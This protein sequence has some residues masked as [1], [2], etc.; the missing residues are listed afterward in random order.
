MSEQLLPKKEVRKWILAM[1]FSEGKY[2]FNRNPGIESFSLAIH[3]IEMLSPRNPNDQM[4]RAALY[5]TRTGGVLRLLEHLKFGF[6]NRQFQ[7]EAVRALLLLKGEERI[8]EKMQEETEL[9]AIAFSNSG[10]LRIKLS[11]VTPWFNEPTVDFYMLRSELHNNL[12]ELEYGVGEMALK[13]IESEN[14]K[15]IKKIRS[16]ETAFP[17]SPP[18]VEIRGHMSKPQRQLLVTTKPVQEYL[19]IIRKVASYYR[20]RQLHIEPIM[21]NFGKK[22][23]SAFEQ[24]KLA[25]PLLEAYHELKTRGTKPELHIWLWGWSSSDG[26]YHRG[27]PEIELVLLRMRFEIGKVCP[28]HHLALSSSEYEFTCLDLAND[29]SQKDT[30]RSKIYYDLFLFLDA[31]QGRSTIR[32]FVKCMEL[33]AT[34]ANKRQLKQRM[35]SALN[36]LKRI[37]NGQMYSNCVEF[38]REHYGNI[39]V[40]E[41]LSGLD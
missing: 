8:A 33:T 14:R 19:A 28:S 37:D 36:G 17:I 40:D 32:Y 11:E 15:A 5:I 38:L 4:Y 29:E 25:K 18:W 10:S 16:I 13:L 24:L 7:S 41:L 35:E 39:Y 27:C 21:V 31:K 9:Q 1:Q 6:Q 2:L 30:F 20:T 3:L 22:M 26:W 12:D 34:Y 23:E